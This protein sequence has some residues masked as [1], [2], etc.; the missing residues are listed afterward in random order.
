MCPLSVEWPERARREVPAKSLKPEY[1]AGDLAAELEAQLRSAGD[2]ASREVLS[3]LIEYVAASGAES[4]SKQRASTAMEWAAKY[5]APKYD[6]SDLVPGW[7]SDLRVLFDAV[8]RHAPELLRDWRTRFPDRAVD[9]MQFALALAGRGPWPEQ[10][11]PAVARRYLNTPAGSFLYENEIPKAALVDATRALLESE[12]LPLLQWVRV[13][14]LLVGADDGFRALILFNY[15]AQDFRSRAFWLADASGHEL[16]ERAEASLQAGKLSFAG[17]ISSALVVTRAKGRQWSGQIP[18][19]VRQA[20]LWDLR[21]GNDVEAAVS[22]S[23]YANLTEELAADLLRECM[24]EERAIA[25]IPAIRDDGVIAELFSRIEETG[26]VSAVAIDALVACG[27]RAVPLLVEVCTRKG[28]NAALAAACAEV[29]GRLAVTQSPAALVALLGHSSKRVVASAAKALERL[30]EL[31]RVA[32]DDGIRSTKKAVRD[33]CTRLLARLVDQSTSVRTPLTQVRGAVEQLPR[34]A[35]D[36][37]LLALRGAGVGEAAWHTQLKPQVQALGAV[38]LELLR[39]W[40]SEKVEEG[41]TRLW[42]YAVE[43]LRND[44]AA[45]WVAVDTFARMPKL[46]ASLWARPRR[47]LGHCGQLLG[48]PIVHC[49]RNVHT[50]YR[51]VL[52]GLLAAHAAAVDPAIFL[53][54]LSD[55]SKAVRTH[56]VDG[57]SR[58]SDGPLDQTA[59]LLEGTE[60]GTRIAAA[61][62]LAVWGDARS[63]DAVARAWSNERSGKVRPY[64]E[65]TLLACG[66]EDL[67]F[68][69]LEGEP[70]SNEAVEAFLARQQLPKKLPGFLRLDELP[71]LRFGNGADL[72][73]AARRGFLARLTML[74]SSLKG[75]PVRRLLQLLDPSDVHAWGRW[76]YDGWAKARNSKHKWAMLQLSLLADEALIGDALSKIGQWR[77][78]EHTAI[79]CHL[80]A[81]QWHGSDEAVA[82]LGYW[83][84]NLA[85]MGGR[86]TARQLLDRVAFKRGC[87][88]QQLRE[89][90]DPFLLEAREEAALEQELPEGFLRERL[91][92]DIERAW[93]TGRY[94]T[95]AAFER[96][97]TMQRY[98]RGE[99]LLLRSANGALLRHWNGA[100]RWW[101]AQSGNSHALSPAELDSVGGIRLAHPLELDESQRAAWQRGL[102]MPPAIEQSRRA[103]FSADQFDEVAGLLAPLQRFS[104]WRRRNRWFHGEP[105]D[106]GIVYTDSLQLLGRN[107][108]VTLHHS[109]YGIGESDF[110]EDVRL[111]EVDFSDLDGAPV[112]PQ[113]LCP[114]LCSELQ[115]SLSDLRRSEDE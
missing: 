60:M 7:D 15:C 65:D 23:A 17:A 104:K 70:L 56:S 41:E 111:L 16:I 112:D 103:T 79:G 68:E 52:Y 98:L 91:L 38:A 21:C 55:P 39:D 59:A 30:D 5:L 58:N 92:R 22:L 49:L 84:E 12:P 57:L 83:S 10:C 72:T 77:G 75:R 29:L 113:S 35:R 43:E 50:E 34:G 46:S 82:W 20:L 1:T 11:M 63:A 6:A 76:V 27:E 28:P 31:S 109:G 13:E 67:V 8:A 71:A 86:T 32:L 48:E 33:Q 47:A 95:P 99:A 90:F 3:L 114:V 2:S 42:C 115:L 108:I 69:L 66:R 88:L 105:M 19:K 107:L 73:E 64:L 102:H 14:D 26:Q 101:D 4:F 61:E 100:W 106:A 62:L 87:T 45:V 54:G 40:F 24:S 37:F 85:S 110:E 94:W 81:A 89:Q 78:S 9:Q 25:L 53:S 96:L 97:F 18:E 80:R 74:E 93:I 44:S 51:E 36:E